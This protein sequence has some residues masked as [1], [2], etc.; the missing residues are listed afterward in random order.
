M[1]ASCSSIRTAIARWSAPPAPSTGSAASASSPAQPVRPCG[2]SIATA[3]CVD[4]PAAVRFVFSR[5]PVTA[6]FALPTLLLPVPAVAT[7]RSR[8]GRRR[9]GH[10]HATS[11]EGR[12]IRRAGPAGRV[13]LAGVVLL[14]AAVLAFGVFAPPE[15]CPE[16][17]AAGLDAGA[18]AA[19]DWFTRNQH[20]EGTWLYEYDAG[21][22]RETGRRTTW[23]ATPGR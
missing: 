12:L 7:G 17:T 22:D 15:H 16:V 1:I 8:A 3:A 14:L 18:T 23:C 19:V 5:L 10:G 21:G 4:G 2:S 20:A 13:V 11:P 9:A 6:W